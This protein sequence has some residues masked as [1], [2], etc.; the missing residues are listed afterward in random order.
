M[1]RLEA[2]AKRNKKGLWADKNPINLFEWRKAE[3]N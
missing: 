3:R 2:E 1:D